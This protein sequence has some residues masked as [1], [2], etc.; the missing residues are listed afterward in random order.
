MTYGK[1]PTAVDSTGMAANTSTYDVDGEP[2][3]T[4][5]LGTELDFAGQQT[6]P[7]TGSSTCA[8]GTTT[9]RAG[10]LW[11]AS[12]WPMHRDRWANGYAFG[13]GNPARFSDPTGLYPIDER[14]C[15]QGLGWT[16]TVSAT[17]RP[18]MP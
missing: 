9:R 12:R 15:R 5:S 6:D 2:T 8:R 17:P 7:S 10:R 16:Q 18:D 13:S 3:V 11:A 4:G 14:G 1:L